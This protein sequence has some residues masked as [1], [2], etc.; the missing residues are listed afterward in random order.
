MRAIVSGHP[1]SGIATQQRLLSR[2]LGLPVITIGDAVR[3]EV[4][5]D[6]AHGR[7]FTAAADRGEPLDDTLLADILAA[8][9]ARADTTAGFLLGGL[10]STV[11][12]AVLLDQRLAESDTRLDA[13]V[14]LA[15]PVD[16]IVERLVTSG[17]PGDPH[18]LRLRIERLESLHAPVLD[19]YRDRAAQ[20]RVRLRLV[21]GTGSVDAVFTRIVAALR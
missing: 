10:P 18:T 11:E 8:R 14:G 2:Q 21:S 19:H 16:V 7:R 15:L 4:D 1:Q 12:Q 13:I 6:T 9:L 5:A 3:A 17:Y 20:G